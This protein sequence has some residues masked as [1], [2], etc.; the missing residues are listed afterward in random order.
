MMKIYSEIAFERMTFSCGRTG[1][2]FAVI[3]LA[4]EKSERIQFNGSAL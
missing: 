3:K 1:N 4:N 2:I